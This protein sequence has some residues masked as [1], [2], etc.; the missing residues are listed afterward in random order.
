MLWYRPGTIFPFSL[1]PLNKKNNKKKAVSKNTVEFVIDKSKLST[2][3]KSTNRRIS[4]WSKNENPSTLS[5]ANKLYELL[6]IM[7]KAIS[8][9]LSCPNLPHSN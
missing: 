3:C 6:L 9:F 8:F 1:L 5:C 2:I 4:N 7:N